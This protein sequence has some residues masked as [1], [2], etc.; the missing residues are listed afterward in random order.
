MRDI[1]TAYCTEHMTGSHCRFLFWNTVLSWHMSFRYNIYAHGGTYMVLNTGTVLHGFRV[2]RIREIDDCSGVL[3][4]M[5]HLKTGAQL[6]WMK[7]D[8]ENKTFVIALKLAQF[9]FLH[10]T[11]SGTTPLL[12]LDDIF[13]R[14]DAERVERIVR[15]V[16]SN[17]F[18]QTFITDTNRDHLDKILSITEL[19]YKLFDCQNGQFTPVR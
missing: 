15:L 12:L 9:E 6:C 8:D 11:G 7:R 17:R 16:G 13:D 4:E 14:L 2:E 3:Y 5:T 10:R 1:R 19:D 18:G